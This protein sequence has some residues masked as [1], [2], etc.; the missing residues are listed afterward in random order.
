MRNMDLSDIE[1]LFKEGK[2]WKDCSH[3][4]QSLSSPWL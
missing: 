4:S 3:E 2:K 1:N